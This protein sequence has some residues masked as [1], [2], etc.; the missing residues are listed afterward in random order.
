MGEFEVRW[1]ILFFV[2]LMIDEHVHDHAPDHVVK[3]FYY[4]V[5]LSQCTP[6]HALKYFYDYDLVRCML[7]N[8]CKLYLKFYLQMQLVY[9]VFGCMLV[10]LVAVI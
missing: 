2:L 7:V 4:Y 5:L 6:D 8:T 1:M 9:G 3:Y 10:Y